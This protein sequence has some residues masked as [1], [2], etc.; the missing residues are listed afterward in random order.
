M[1]QD[2][3]ESYMVLF[4]NNQ[5]LAAQ[6]MSSFDEWLVQSEATSS[7]E[8]GEF[9]EWLARPKNFGKNRLWPYKPVEEQPLNDGGSVH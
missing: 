1:I 3:K 9:I 6:L 8:K 2:A 5:D 4:K 7:Q